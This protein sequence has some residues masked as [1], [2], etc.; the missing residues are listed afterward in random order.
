MYEIWG[1]THRQI[2]KGD[3]GQM[4]VVEAVD[5]NGK[6]VVVKLGLLDTDPI[7]NPRWAKG[8][9]GGPGTKEKLEKDGWIFL[10]KLGKIPHVEALA[11][12]D[13]MT[14]DGTWRTPKEKIRE[15]F[16]DKTADETSG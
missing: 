6:R 10:E 5:E 12:Y 14:N 9:N 7:S 11:I 4:R 3:N 16:R 2:H 8:K 15:V 13:R 1:K